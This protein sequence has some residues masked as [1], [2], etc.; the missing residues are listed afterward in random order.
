MN[1]TVFQRPDNF[2]T[3]GFRAFKQRKKNSTEEETG[4]VFNRDQVFTLTLLRQS[5][6]SL[7]PVESHRL[8]KTY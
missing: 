1:A 7:P 8:N 2:Y 4:F 6:K 5:L 3:P